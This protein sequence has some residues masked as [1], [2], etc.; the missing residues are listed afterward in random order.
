MNEFISVSIV[1]VFKEI[2]K[3]GRIWLTFLDFKSDKKT[4]FMYQA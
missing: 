2:V 1:T 4:S 3:R